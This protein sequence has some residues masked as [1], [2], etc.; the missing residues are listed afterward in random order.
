MRPAS[1]L[2][3]FDE[4]VFTR[5]LHVLSVDVLGLGQYPVPLEELSVRPPEEQRK[6]KL[7][8]SFSMW[9]VACGVKHT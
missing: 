3:Q 8:Q 9:H 7:V 6:T 1:Y 5:F 4:D 2:Y